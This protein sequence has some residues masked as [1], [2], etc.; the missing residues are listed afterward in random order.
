MGF[1]RIRTVRDIRPGDVLAHEMTELSDQ[2]S[3][4]S[5]GH[6]LMFDTAPRPIEPKEPVVPGTTQFEARIID[7]STDPTG[8]DDTRLADR[9]KKVTGAGRGTLR[10]YADSDGTLVGWART[11]KGTKRF[12]SYDPRFPSDTKPRRVAVGRPITG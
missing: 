11:F 8:P 9:S 3:A 7:S 1:Q 6:V 12:F 5:T 2:K 4:L 10:L